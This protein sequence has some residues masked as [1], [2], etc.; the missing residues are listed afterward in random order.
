[1]GSLSSRP[2]TPQV[3]YVVQSVPTSSSATTSDSSASATSTTTE[4]TESTEVAAEVRE[5]DLLRRQR[6]R[7]GT[8]LTSFR[9][10]ESAADAGAD[11]AGRKTL[12]GE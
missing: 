5:D 11:S 3:T 12:L 7:S 2:K 1:M 10:L 9:G 6:G 4:A 8:V